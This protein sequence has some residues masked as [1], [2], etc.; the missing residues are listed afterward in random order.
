MQNEIVSSLDRP[1]Q[2]QMRAD[3]L[4]QQQEY[5]GRR[6]WIIKDPLGLK[7]YRFEEEEFAI[8]QMLDGKASLEQIQRRFESRYAPQKIAIQ[9]LHQ[10]VGML[11]RSALI[12]AN[13]PDQGQEL[14]KRRTKQERRQRVGAL[15]NVLGIRFRGINPDRLLGGLN[16]C[17]GWFF[18]WPAFICSG[19]LMGSALLLLISQFDQFQSRLPEFQQF[20]AVSN[21]GWLFVTLAVTKILH[22]FGHGLACKRFGGECNEMGVMLLVLTPCLYCNVSDSWMLP[23][24]WKRAAIGAAGMYV[25][26]VLASLCTF[27]WWFSEPGL[28]NYLC[29]NVMFV[30]SVS[31]LLFNA[32][33]LLRYDGYYILSDLIEIPNLRQK[34]STILNRKLGN[35]CLGFKEPDDPFLP[36]RRQWLF[37]CYSLAAVVY[38]WVVVISILWFLNQVFEPYGLQRLGQAIAMVAV[39][40]L[41]VHP[42]IQFIRFLSVPGRMDTVN[43]LRFLVSSGVV[44]SVLAGVCLVPL[45][46]YVTC[47]LQ[48][49]LHDAEPVYVD[50]SGE[51]DAIHVKPGTFVHEGDKLLTLSNLDAQ[52]EIAQLNGQASQL[53]TKIQS[54]RQRAFEEEAVLL[55]LTQVEEALETINDLRRQRNADL[56]R[57][58]IRA[59]SSGVVLPADSRPRESSRQQL[60]SWSGRLLDRQNRG[61]F[62]Q[63]GTMVCQVGDPKRLEAV[64]AIDQ[65]DLEFISEGQKIQILLQ[66]FP[67]LMLNSKIEQIAEVDMKKSP[68]GMSN[69]SGGDLATQTD[70]AGQE[71]PLHTKYHAN[72][73]IRHESAEIAV[74][75]TGTARI[76]A[77]S[78]TIGQRLVRY[79]AQTFRF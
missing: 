69:K 64:L 49:Q 32:N 71:Q 67:W 23:N 74:G 57:L 6:Y 42:L 7:Y 39:Y 56:R 58:T 53:T 35:W 72:A 31:T 62:A 78:K 60:A 44:A 25:E 27:L 41:A 13:T 61:A 5:L 79:L 45:P 34:A 76:R 38:R 55:E 28:L 50:V 52:L 20:F 63:E 17:L 33:P 18:S 46:F 26:L 3:L 70:D 66:Q 73:T 24:K 59:T 11:F 68:R 36:Q 48:I 40:G 1:L 10:F 9:E 19:L 21:W 43:R 54:L 65:A 51:V 30:S 14:L 37:A 15:A 2:L 8:L 29:L 12:V 47:S 77:G 16:R 75:A 4:C 22:E